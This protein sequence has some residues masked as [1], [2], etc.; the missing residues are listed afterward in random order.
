MVPL[1]ATLMEAVLLN[2]ELEVHD[3]IGKEGDLTN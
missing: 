2:K 3:L 1:G